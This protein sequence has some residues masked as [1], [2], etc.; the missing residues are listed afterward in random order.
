MAVI[1]ALVIIAIFA[2]VVLIDEISVE[3]EKSIEKNKNIIYQTNQFIGPELWG[4]PDLV[5]G[6]IYYLSHPCTTGGGSIEFNKQ[7]EE[8]LYRKI[9]KRNPDAKVIRPLKIIPDGTPH[10][11]AMKRC[12]KI[13]DLADGIILPSGWS[14]STGCIMEC[15][16]AITKGLEIF[17]LTTD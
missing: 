1:I 14:K 13:L 10:N 2:I 16:K 7:R 4:I 9:I 15:E 3:M 17:L 6:N 11:V 5:P 8:E 12:M